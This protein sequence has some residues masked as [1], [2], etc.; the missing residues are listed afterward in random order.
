MQRAIGLG[1]GDAVEVEVAWG[2]IGWVRM[3]RADR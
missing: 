3:S 1:A 2:A